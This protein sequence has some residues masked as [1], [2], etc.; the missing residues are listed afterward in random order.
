[1]TEQFNED[2][3]IEVYPGPRG[4]SV[5]GVHTSPDGTTAHFTTDEPATLNPIPLPRG[6]RGFK[7]EYGDPGE[8]RIRID[9]TVGYRVFL[10]DTATMGESM[11][12][13]DTGVW[14]LPDSTLVR[15]TGNL[16]ET[17]A[18]TPASL[19]AGFRPTSTGVSGLFM[20]SEPWPTQV[21][22]TVVVDAA[23]MRGLGGFE[24][25]V[26]Q[27]FPGTAEQWM[28][29][30]YGVLPTD[31]K[32]GQWLTFT[33]SGPAW[34]ALPTI[35]PSPWVN[36]TLN[37]NWRPLSSG[38]CKVRMNNGTVE[39]MGGVR[40][41]GKNA[42]AGIWG[43]EFV[44]I[45]TIPSNLAPETNPNT[46]VTVY[47]GLPGPGNAPIPGILSISSAGAIHVGGYERFDKHSPLRMLAGHTS[48]ALSGV[49]FAA[50]V[51]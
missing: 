15:R 2:G 9:T 36:V 47:Q 19:P 45:G 8:A 39:F 50:R 18:S 27:G 40:Y 26:A 35:G 7:G 12:Y 42:V 49:S 6:P 14:R 17:D 31:G 32:V 51:P 37:S 44:R 28:A 13:G 1:M 22:G 48:V 43:D 33:A 41:Q 30:V 23:P 11:V 38:I 34:R 10:W 24:S 21:Y 16:V 4:F 20:T 5:N 46:P 3:N 29:M 25:A